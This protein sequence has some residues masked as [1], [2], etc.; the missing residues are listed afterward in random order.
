MG[1]C[2]QRKRCGDAVVYA[3][4]RRQYCR[5]RGGRVGE[6]GEQTAL[7]PAIV[8]CVDDEEL[9]LKALQRALRPL[10]VTVRCALSGVEALAVLRAEPVAVVISD[11]RM[12]QMSGAQLLAEIARA[13][14]DTFRVVLTG[15]ADMDLTVA[16]IN[17]GRIGCYLSKP[18]DD[19]RLRTVVRDALLRV[20]LLAENKR[21]VQLTGEQNAALHAQNDELERRVAARTHDLQAMADA[22]C[23]GMEELRRSHDNMVALTSAVIALR[24]PAGREVAD[25]RGPLARATAEL[26]QVPPGEVKAIGDASKLLAIGQLALP[27][28]LLHK[29]RPLMK[30]AERRLFESHPLFAE[31]ALHAIA[32]LELAARF[33]RAQHEH[34]DGTGFP[35][36]SAG[37]AIPFGARILAVVRDYFDLQRGALL[38]QPLSDT[39]ARAFVIRH[40]GTWYDPEVVRAFNVALVNVGVT[41][42]ADFEV[43]IPFGAL[44]AGMQLSRDLVTAEGML[45]LSRLHLLTDALVARL[46]SLVERSGVQLVIHVTRSSLNAPTS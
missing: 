46:D 3:D 24:D 26:L 18:W 19:E 42:C 45:L 2:G 40:A 27:D 8:L 31:T 41:G 20:Q 13:W 43:R 25:L 11:M 32:D 15:F 21:L 35:D 33:I 22:L 29:P 1:A 23:A 12:P 36:R 6:S 16:A 4:D 37:G 34:F 44:R 10:G 9:I 30:L 5:D 7:Y 39:A 38:E 28:E 17:D 14:P